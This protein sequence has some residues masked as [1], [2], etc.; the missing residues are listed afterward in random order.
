MV[1]RFSSTCRA[2]WTCPYFMGLI[3]FDELYLLAGPM[4]GI[5]LLNTYV[6]E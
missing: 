5:D 4:D 6:A 3:R 2:D 1:A